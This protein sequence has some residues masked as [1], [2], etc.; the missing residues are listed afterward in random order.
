[1]L[2]NSTNI[3]KT[4][5]LLS[6]HITEHKNKMA[7]HSLGHQ[8]FCLGQAYKCNGLK[9]KAWDPNRIPLGNW[10]SNSSTYINKRYKKT[11]AYSF[12]FTSEHFKHILLFYT[13]QLD[14]TKV[15]HL[16]NVFSKS[17][18][19]WLLFNAKWTIYIRWD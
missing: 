18:G 9:L 11:C 8:G 4:N 14:R 15:S 7:T 2:N 6:P 10:I 19:E 5:N 12:W 1:M 3:N 17:V 16:R 13:K